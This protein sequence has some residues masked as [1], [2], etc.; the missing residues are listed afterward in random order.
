ML[1]I[2]EAVE[3]PEPLIEI[4]LGLI[5]IRGDLQV[6]LSNPL[7]QRRGREVTELSLASGCVVVKHRGLGRC[8][9]TR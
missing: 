4:R 1:E 8:A 5:G 7:H 3:E 2:P 6:G 9:S